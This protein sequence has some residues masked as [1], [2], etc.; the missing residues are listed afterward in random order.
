MVSFGRAVKVVLHKL[1][2]DLFRSWTIGSQFSSSNGT[3]LDFG[4][5]PG[6]WKPGTYQS[7]C[8]AANLVSCHR[9]PLE[10]EGQYYIAVQVKFVDTYGS[11]T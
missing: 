5:R 1:Y 8:A 10:N 11:E 2:W 7:H 4:V 6:L 9:G 3:E